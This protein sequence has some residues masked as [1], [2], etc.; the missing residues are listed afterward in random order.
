MV[1]QRLK[2]AGM[3]WSED[4]PD[5][6]CHLRAMFR[7]EVA[8]MEFVLVAKPPAGEHLIYSI[9]KMPTRCVR[10]DTVT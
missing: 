10:C 2:L 8:A 4:G 6:M 3:R 5:E 1:N 9:N 7:S